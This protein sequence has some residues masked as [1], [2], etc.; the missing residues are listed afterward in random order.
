MSVAASSLHVILGAGQVGAQLA[1][2]RSAYEGI[3][4]RMYMAMPVVPLEKGR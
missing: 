3:V 2:V 4:K 1:G